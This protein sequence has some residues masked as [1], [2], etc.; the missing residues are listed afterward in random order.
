MTKKKILWSGDIVAMTGFAR[1]TENLITRLDDTY[2]IT[3]LG[4]NWW[5]DPAPHLQ[6]RFRML[7]SSNRHQQEPF[8]VQRI[9]EVVINEKPDLVFVNNDIWIVNQIYSQIEDLHKQGKFKFVAYC[10]MDSYEWAGGLLDKSP[11]WDQLVIYTKFG[12]EEFM[13]AGYPKE[14][15]VIPHGVTTTQFST[16]DKAECRRRLGLKEDM[17]VVFNGNR[18]QAR[19]RQDVTI[20]AF[21]DFAVDKPDA[22]LYMHMGLKDQGWD[23]MSVFGQEMR[24]RGL[25]PNGRIIMTANKPHPPNVP[26]EMLNIIYNAVDVGVNTCKGEGHGLVNHEH[27][28]CGVAQVVPNHTS[29]KEIFEGAGLLIDTAF[30]D[31]D[32]NFNRRMPIP[33]AK[34]LTEILNDLY[35]DREKL[36]AIGQACKERALN[37]MYQWDTVANDFREL[38]AEVLKEEPEK[39]EE[40]V[41]PTPVLVSK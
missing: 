19:K 40:V 12:A 2:E 16:L 20:E 15:A 5:G 31:V 29:L 8:G 26:V 32:L 18:N 28:A 14:I 23:I 24:K 37:P 7:P 6:S 33:S 36:K 21:A 25:D 4:N 27:A 34:H 3:V 1:V 11:A 17:F 41:E 30:V 22:M 13:K 10:P 39:A 38:F 35:Y 9:R